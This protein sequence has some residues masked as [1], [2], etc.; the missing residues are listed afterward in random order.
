VSS[1]PPSLAPP[2]TPPPPAGPPRPDALPGPYTTQL[3]PAEE[4][5]F[6][7]WIK[8]NKIPWQDS[9]T[10]DYDMRGYWKAQQSG[11]PNAKQGANLHF[12]DTYKTPYH[13]SFSNESKYALPVAPHWTNQNQQVDPHGKVT[14]DDRWP[15]DHARPA[16]E[17]PSSSSSPALQ[18]PWAKKGG[19]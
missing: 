6:Q 10:A 18:P 5:Q 11:D 1:S 15:E 7:Q 13:R 17:L 16:W 2:P 4:I 12:P 9:P 14:W 3:S 8:A 19:S